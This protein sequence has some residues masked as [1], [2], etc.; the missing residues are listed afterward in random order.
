MRIFNASRKDA[1]EDQ[2]TLGSVDVSGIDKKP[3]RPLSEEA[4]DLSTKC[5]RNKSKPGSFSSIFSCF[6][7]I[8]WTKFA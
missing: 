3:G 8:S 5:A 4:E 7:R 1:K 2:I 6:V